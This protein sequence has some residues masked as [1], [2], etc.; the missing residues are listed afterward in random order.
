MT[1]FQAYISSVTIICICAM[2]AIVYT[3]RFVVSSATKEG[4]NKDQ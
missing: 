4:W 3:A 1:D 2:I